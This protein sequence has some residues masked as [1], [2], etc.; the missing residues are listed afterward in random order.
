[1]RQGLKQSVQNTANAFASVAQKITSAVWSQ[2][3]HELRLQAQD[4]AQNAV[5]SV[6]MVSQGA[7]QPTEQ[8]QAAADFDRSL[9]QEP[10]QM[11]FENAAAIVDKRMDD[12]FEEQDISSGLFSGAARQEM[13]TIKAQ[14]KDQAIAGALELHQ[15]RISEEYNDNF[16]A[17]VERGN[18]QELLNFVNESVQSN[19]VAPWTADNHLDEGLAAIAQQGLQEV[20]IA[21]A[22]DGQWQSALETTTV[23]T[24]EQMSEAQ[25]LIDEGDLEGAQELLGSTYADYV[26]P[27]TD[28]I[29]LLGRDQIREVRGQVQ[30]M[31]EDHNTRVRQGS[32]NNY[33]RTIMNGLASGS[34]NI[35][36]VKQQI[37]N[38]TALDITP[39]STTDYR[40]KLWNMLDEAQSALEEG[41]LSDFEFLPNSVRQEFLNLA[42]DENVPEQAVRSWMG[43]QEITDEAMQE[44]NEYAEDIEWTQRNPEVREAWSRVQSYFDDRRQEAENDNDQDALRKIADQ[45][46]WS[47]R[48]F[49]RAMTNPDFIQQSEGFRTATPERAAH[50]L[51]NAVLSQVGESG[52]SFQRLFGARGLDPS[53]EDYGS[54]EIWKHANDIPGMRFMRNN[55]QTLVRILKYMQN[56]D[57][58][59]LDPERR[60]QVQTSIA[61][62]M[63]FAFK[64][65]TGFDGPV[66][67]RALTDGRVVIVRPAQRRTPHA[68]YSESRGTNVH[69]YTL[70]WNEDKGETEWK[71][72]SRTEG[73]YIGLPGD[74]GDMDPD[75]AAEEQSSDQGGGV[76]EFFRNL[77]NGGD[78]E[79]QER[80]NPSN[81]PSPEVF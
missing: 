57:L 22:S 47:M 49:L 76:G 31:L 81:P 9:S 2:K 16:S 60:A 18:P 7:T 64:D 43:Q 72:W 30:Q 80:A 25:R 17:Y 32:F 33:Q 27:R 50:Q 6:T 12:W 35:A 37:A 15:K 3:R 51:A 54:T 26:D 67:T 55:P 66:E 62:G 77:F 40:N 14:A 39:G 78:D 48:T 75:F 63:E 21:L 20:A 69:A 4:V 56:K 8:S 53:R 29:K 5:R 58:M 79:P 70:E 19:V 23:P 1:M 61:E 13:E 44:L 41:R 24:E 71:V 46:A 42:M 38:D 34:L 68:V 36:Q 65:E 52:Q 73:E 11:R 59:T 45:R 10:A 28:Q 74:W